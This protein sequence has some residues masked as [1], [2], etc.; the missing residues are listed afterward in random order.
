LK[1]LCAYFHKNTA[2]S[3]ITIITICNI[4]SPHITIIIGSSKYLRNTASALPLSGVNG[5]YVINLNRRSD[6]M[7]L[8]NESSGLQP[9]DFHRFSAVDGKS[10]KSSP[11][12]INMFRNNRFESRSS[13][14]GYSLSHYRLWKHIASTSNEMHLVVE[15]DAR[16]AK[17]WVRRWNKSYYPDLPK[18]AY[19]DT[20]LFI[21]GLFTSLCRSDI[22]KK[23]LFNNKITTLFLFLPH[24]LFSITINHCL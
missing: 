5:I 4:T 20:V 3:I 1:A 24:E 16:L 12:I 10:L 19:V 2:I 7:R 21:Y 18:N 13:I 8:F 15:D 6:R 17:G 23:R 14:I 22:V 11:R 9:G